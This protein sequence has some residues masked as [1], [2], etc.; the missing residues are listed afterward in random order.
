MGVQIIANYTY[1]LSAG[2][3]VKAI[4]ILLHSR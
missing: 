4:P 3:H 2:Y 1:N